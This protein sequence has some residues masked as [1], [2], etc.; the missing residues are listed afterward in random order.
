[1]MEDGWDKKDVRSDTPVPA[2]REDMM[3]VL[4]DL[5]YLLV[6]ATYDDFQTEVR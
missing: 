5:E 3:M 1:M 4:E 6:K 2:S